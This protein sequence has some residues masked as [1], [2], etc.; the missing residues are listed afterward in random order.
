M[1]VRAGPAAFKLDKTFQAMTLLLTA[2]F[3]K[4]DPHAFRLDDALVVAKTAIL[5]NRLDK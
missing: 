5:V 3:K 1:A 2:A 4:F